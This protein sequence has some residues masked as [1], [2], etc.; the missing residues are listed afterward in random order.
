M[1]F[2]LHRGEIWSFR[3]ALWNDAMVFILFR[4]EIDLFVMLFE[5][6]LFVYFALWRNWS[7][8]NVLWNDAMV[9]IL[10]RCEIYLFV[11]LFE[12]ILLFLFCIVEKL[13]F[14]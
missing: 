2:I 14:S 7:V 8:R 6:I 9:F 3:N 13:I 1:V 5:T 10:Y 4:R 11:M 12:T